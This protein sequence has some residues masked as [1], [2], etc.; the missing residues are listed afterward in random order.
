MKTSRVNNQL[1]E[2]EE[3]IKWDE[4]EAFKIEAVHE[5]QYTL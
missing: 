3:D 2:L 5:F 1:L 4:D